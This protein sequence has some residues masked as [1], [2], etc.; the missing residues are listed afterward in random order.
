VHDCGQLTLKALDLYQDF[1]DK[2]KV[3]LW[4]GSH[5]GYLIGM[6][7]GHPDYC[8]LWAAAASRNPVLNMSFM[9]SSTD[10]PDWMYACVLNKSMTFAEL[11]SAQNKAFFD[12]SPINLIKNVKT[13]TLLLIGQKDLRVPHS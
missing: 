1:V 13:P 5:G 7:T 9:L 4:G 3:T 12:R 2:S 10:I 6:L 11:S 8:H